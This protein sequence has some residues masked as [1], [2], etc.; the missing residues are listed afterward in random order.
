M[1]KENNLLKFLIPIIAV[2]VVFESIVLV[3]NLDKGVKTN[4][5]ISNTSEATNSALVQSPVA[6]EPVVD[7]VF[8]TASTEMKVGK[9]YKV[10]LNVMGKQDLTV[11]GIETYIKYDPNLM[12]VSGLS[13]NTKLPKATVSAVDNKNGIIKNIILVEDELGYKLEQDKVNLVLSFSVTPKKEGMASF[14]ISSGN[15]NK[16]FVTMIVENTT[17]KALPFSVNKLEIN[18]TK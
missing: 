5:N 13:S 15:A 7:M 18:M 3:T 4:T 9:T 16:E 1:N 12:T 8:A 6:E 14:E 10:Q 11:S 17:V 2:V